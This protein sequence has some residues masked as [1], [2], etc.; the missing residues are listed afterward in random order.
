LGAGSWENTLEAKG[1]ICS[2][3]LF[4]TNPDFFP[5]VPAPA[6]LAGGQVVQI[7]Q[8]I[9]SRLRAPYILQS[10]ETIE[11]Q[12]PANTTVAVTYTNSHGLHMLRSQDINAPLP[13]TYNPNV[14]DN[15]LYPLGR[16]GA[17]ELMESFGI[18]NQNQ[19]IAN[20][21]SKVNAG[22]SLF[23]FY[24]FNRA[25]SNTDGIGT[26][27][28]N[29]YNFTGEY[30]PA[31]TDVHHRATIGGSINLRWAVR[32]SPFVVMQSGAPFDITSGNDLYGTTLFNSRPGS[33]NDASRLGLIAIPYGLLDPNPIAGERLVPRNY[34]RGPGIYNF[35]IRIAKTIGFGRERGSGGGDPHGGG[36]PG[37]PMQAATGRGLGG[38]IAPSSTAHRCNLSIGLS[39]RNLFNHTN[40]GPIVG[41]ISSPYF[42]FCEPDGG[43]GQ[44]R[45]ILRD[46]EQPAVGIATQAD[47]LGRGRYC[48]G[49]GEATALVLESAA[50]GTR[51]VASNFRLI[52]ADGLDSG[53]GG[54][55]LCR[56]VQIGRRFDSGVSLRDQERIL[57]L[58]GVFFLGRNLGGHEIH[59]GE[60]GFE[61]NRRG[62]VRASEDIAESVECE[63]GKFLRF[64]AEE[65]SAVILC[66]AEG[67]LEA[68]RFAAPIAD[69]VTV[70]ASFSGGLGDART[71]GDG[72]EG[73]SLLRGED[74]LGHTNH[75]LFRP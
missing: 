69:G 10:A 35:N 38:L 66:V 64:F 15:G 42:R 32:I 23:G 57:D 53:D 60:S 9:S 17:V 46:G 4:I 45:R 59:H 6:T 26:F 7:V 14:P 27:P 63:G 3:N 31:A 58:D 71:S 52:P 39:I 34:G 29:A 1:M 50:T 20:L 11:R 75:F 40:A 48:D 25:R 67:E 28:A 61:P 24:V 49:F 51:F 8:E 22:L 2:S 21:N 55:R 41:N 47:V 70:D 65:E 73:D 56:I 12:L 74:E 5:N 62:G 54:F 30:G 18:Y 43:V 68:D 72:I 16:R 19:L 36:G 13:G 37:N 44:Q 33:A